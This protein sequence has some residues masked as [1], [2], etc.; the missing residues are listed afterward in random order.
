VLSNFVFSAAYVGSKGTKLTRLTTPNLGANVTPSIQLADAN[1]GALQNIN[2][3]IIFTDCRLQPNNRCSIAPPRPMPNLGA[4][5]VFS[6]SASSNYHALQLET[7]KRFSQ[8]Y[9]L[10]VAYTWSHAIDDVSDVFALGGAPILPQNTF[11]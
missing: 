1:R 5:Q 8:G 9:T 4:F 6:N 2:F 7:R 3:P 11:N 10:S